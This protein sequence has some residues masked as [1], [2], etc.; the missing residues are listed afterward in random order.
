[1]SVT[2]QLRRDT[3]ANWT[4]ANPVLAQGEIGLQT[5]AEVGQPNAKMGDGSTAWASLGWWSPSGAAADGSGTVTSVAVESANGFEG[6]VAD[7][8]STPQI[9]LSTTVSGLL[10]G[11][12]GALEEAEPGTDYLTPAGNGS[13]LTGITP[14]QVGA[15]ASGAASDAQAAA[16]AAS[17][18]KAGDT[19]GGKLAPAVTELTDGATIAVDAALGNDFYVTIAGD[20]T[21]EAPSS[22]ADGQT[23]IL[24]LIQDGTGS[25]TVTWASG[26]GGYS[27]G[28][29]SAPVLSTA[30]A[31]T[32]QVAFRYSARKEEWL[33]LG[34]MTGF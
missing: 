26:T 24:E 22:P 21:M 2:I 16:E 9:T 14:A 29:G 15:D 32:D 20:R 17:V 31:A 1:M 13:E 6:S 4:A 3:G 19:M 23:L 30:A 25:R 18:A 28:S 34:S 8:T 5:D 12:G 7:S 27:F 33:Y 10:K 11:A